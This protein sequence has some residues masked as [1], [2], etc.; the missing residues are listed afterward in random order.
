VIRIS[1]H[2]NDFTFAVRVV[3]RSSRTEIVGET[4]GA[5]RVRISAPP[6]DGA[7]NRELIR[8]LS[9]A[10]KLPKTA[11]MIVGGASSKHKV[12]RLQDV[13]LEKLERLGEVFGG[14]KT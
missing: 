12:I 1:R 11:I 3:P 8:I 14:I 7:A 13:E 6:V 2:G 9:R 5:L 10:L 4:D